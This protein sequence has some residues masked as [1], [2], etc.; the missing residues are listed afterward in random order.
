MI[1]A[2]LKI[3][4]SP[5]SLKGSTSGSIRKVNVEFYF[6]V[7]TVAISDST[8]R[9]QLHP[10]K[11]S[12]FNR[13]KICPLFYANFAYCKSNIGKQ[14]LHLVLYVKKIYKIILGYLFKISS[15]I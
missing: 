2:Y 4:C 6:D 3:F 15:M 1:Q 13:R 14:Y 8:R 7:F 10:P 9:E 12:V 5:A 11:P